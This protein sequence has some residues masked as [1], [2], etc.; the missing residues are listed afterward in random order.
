MLLLLPIFVCC[1]VVPVCTGSDVCWCRLLAPVNGCCTVV[2]LCIGRNSVGVCCCYYR[3]IVNCCTGMH[4][5]EYSVGWYLLLVPVD[6]WVLLYRYVPHVVYLDFA[7]TILMHGIVL[8]R[9]FRSSSP[10]SS[11][12]KLGEYADLLLCMNKRVHF[13]AKKTYQYQMQ[14]PCIDCT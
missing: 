5:W 10:C 2:L 4:W 8:Q 12:Y 3:M 13:C 11:T 6:S 9:S 1:T 7:V 14:F